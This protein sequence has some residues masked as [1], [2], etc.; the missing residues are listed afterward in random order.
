MNKKPSIKF[1]RAAVV[2]VG[3]IG[4]SLARALRERDVAETVI[5]VDQ[6]EDILAR[7]KKIGVIDHGFSSL[8]EG[9]K[10]A[11]LI[12]LSTPVGALAEICRKVSDCAEDGAL[13]IDVGS[14]KGVVLDAAKALPD[15]IFF[16]P[17]H[18]VAGTE[19]SGPEAGFASLFEKRWCI[20]T[21]LERNDAP[22][23]EAVKQATG[24]WTAIGAEVEVMDAAHHDLALAV[25]S[26]IPH[27]IAF[28]MVGAA[29]DIES[30]AHGEVVKYSAGGFRDF[31]R[32]A[33]SDPV[34]WRDV[35]LNNREAVLEVLGRFSEELAVM[36]R[37]IR[38]G[39]ADVLYNA[40][41]RGRSLRRAIVDAGQETAAPNFGRDEPH[42]SG[43]E[44]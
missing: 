11:D 39:D 22:Y 6:D 10:G 35:F 27:L 34:M 28:T 2:G 13:I 9:V 33:A 18:P 23:L 20:I 40:F 32:I 26:H 44:S 24:L 37:A 19:Q 36:Q 31:T 25:T 17:C 15:R 38:W 1:K 5:G 29:D 41:S 12:I 7:A 21:P 43:E 16:V 4:S 14:V 30:V 8:D 42:D 3:L